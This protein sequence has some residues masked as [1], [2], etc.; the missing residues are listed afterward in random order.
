MTLGIIDSAISLGGI[1]SAT[2]CVGLAQRRQLG[3]V[4]I[5]ALVFLAASLVVFVS[6]RS[7]ALAAITYSVI[8]T[9]AGIFKVL[10]K[11]IVYRLVDVAFAG[12]TM[13][14]ISMA[15]LVISIAVSFL[16]GHVGERS[17]PGAYFMLAGFML[18][19]ACL[20]ALA[21]RKV[22]ASVDV[23]GSL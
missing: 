14:A 9:F 4:T 18:V 7:V 21:Q 5:I 19:P 20:I 6:S 17:L 15:S 8:G 22:A 3:G 10:S 1:L 2:V 13:T 11:S 16:V 12:R 23:P